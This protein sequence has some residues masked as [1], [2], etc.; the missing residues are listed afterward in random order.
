VVKEKPPRVR[1]ES[2]KRRNESKSKRKK[3]RKTIF[4]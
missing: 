4:D 3:I 1:V 2:N